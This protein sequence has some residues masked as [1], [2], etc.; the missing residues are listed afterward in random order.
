MMIEVNIEAR[1]EKEIIV[2]TK[3]GIQINL[4]LS[5]A[6]S[7]FKIGDALWI[8]LDTSPPSEVSPKNILNELLGSNEYEK[9][10]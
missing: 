7:E 3:E 1:N 10:V 9:T 4:P 5:L 2:R 8:S 6:S